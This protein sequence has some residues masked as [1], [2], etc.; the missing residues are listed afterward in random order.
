MTELTQKTEKNTISV[1]LADDHP[2]VQDGI[3]TRFEEV[4]DIEV[5]GVASDGKELLEKAEELHPD[6]IIGA[7]CCNHLIGGLVF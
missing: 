4:D 3:R 7:Y 5:I 2:L 6:I 1:L